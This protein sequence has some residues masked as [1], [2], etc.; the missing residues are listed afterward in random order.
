MKVL[1]TALFPGY[2]FC[3][4]DVRYK[5]PVVSS[6]GVEYIVGVA[7]T[8]VALSE[9]E[10]TRIRLIAEAGACA[11]DNFTCGQRVR[12]MHGLVAGVEGILTQTS[13][14]DRLVVSIDLLNRS[15]SLQIDKTRISII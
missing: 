2:L 3:E 4:F 8:P 12:V 10:M 6:P 1:D 11:A 15:V 5:L 14:G 9:E 7:G 13:D